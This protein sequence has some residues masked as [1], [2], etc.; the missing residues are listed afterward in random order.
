MIQLHWTSCAHVRPNRDCGL[1]EMQ[2]SKVWDPTIIH[3]SDAWSGHSNCIKYIAQGVQG[4]AVA[5]PHF[6]RWLDHE[7]TSPWPGDRADGA[8]H[9]AHAA[10]AAD[11]ADSD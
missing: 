1:H 9:A 11:A 7:T 8:A 3:D 4:V 2:N 10:D 5:A 6:G